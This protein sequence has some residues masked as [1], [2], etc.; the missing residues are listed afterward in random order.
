M[1][2]LTAREKAEIAAAKDQNAAMLDKLAGQLQNCREQGDR[3]GVGILSFII[4]E[5]SPGDPCH[6]CGMRS[7]NGKAVCECGW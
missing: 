3:H 1:R 2:E 6:I 4:N 5:L 7:V